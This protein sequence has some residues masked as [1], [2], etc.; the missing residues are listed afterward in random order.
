MTAVQG[1]GQEAAD[2]DDEDIDF[3]DD[4]VYFSLHNR[5]MLRTTDCSRVCFVNWATS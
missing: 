2:V 4:G 1:D 5:H 3:S